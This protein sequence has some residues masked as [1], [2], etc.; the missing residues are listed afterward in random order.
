MKFAA[1]A[2]PVINREDNVPT[3]VIFGCALVVTVPAVVADPAVPDETAYVALAT[4]PVTLAPVRLLRAEPLPVNTP[5][6]AVILTAVNMPLTPR[7]VNVPVDVMFG[8]AA[9]VSV[10]C[11]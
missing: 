2:L 7:A 5:V 9:V 1:L 8:C 6:L 10:P 3:E 11:T 4:V